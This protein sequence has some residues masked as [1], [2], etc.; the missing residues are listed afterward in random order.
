[1]QFLV[2]VSIVNY[3]YFKNILTGIDSYSSSAS[4]SSTPRDESSSGSPSPIPEDG[5]QASKDKPVV[6]LGLY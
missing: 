4:A 2:K 3:F 5:K 1:M 6:K